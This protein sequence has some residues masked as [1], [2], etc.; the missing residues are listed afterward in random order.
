[1]VKLLHVATRSSY[2]VL[3]ATVLL[4]CIVITNVP[5]RGLWSVVVIIGIILLAVIFA[6]AGWWE[7]IFHY[8]GLL[9]IRINAGGYFFISFILLAVWLV[10]TLLF[11]RQVYILFS[12]GRFRFCQEIGGGEPAYDTMGMVIQKQ[13]D[14]LF[15]HVILGLGSGDLIVRTAGAHSHEFHFN[16]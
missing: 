12:P 10:V 9:D 1:E 11:G 2:G 3:F 14:Y 5:L 15:R 6:L 7:T 16:N 4:L 13:R 8:L